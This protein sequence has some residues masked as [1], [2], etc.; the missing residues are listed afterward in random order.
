MQIFQKGSPANLG[1]PTRG[2][3]GCGRV[4]E[5]RMKEEEGVWCAM[6]E[7]DVKQGNKD[8]PGKPKED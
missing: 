7:G 4:D 5:E 3:H 1:L 2:D 6:T 8:T